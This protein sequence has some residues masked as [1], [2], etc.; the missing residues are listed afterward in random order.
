MD[1]VV[2]DEDIQ[3][4]YLF[5]LSYPKCYNAWRVWIISVGVS[6]T[7]ARNAAI[8]ALQKWYSGLQVLSFV[9]TAF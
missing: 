4:D 9:T 6:L 7:T 2:E 5:S 3:M 1:C 8:Q